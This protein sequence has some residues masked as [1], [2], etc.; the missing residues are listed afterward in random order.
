MD[1]PVLRNVALLLGD[2]WNICLPPLSNSEDTLKAKLGLLAACGGD[3]APT[4]V[5]ALV[6]GT[7]TVLKG[8][9][10][11]LPQPAAAYGNAGQVPSDR[12]TFKEKL[13]NHIFILN[14]LAPFSVGS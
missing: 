7:R 1:A 3:L 8:T 5:Q 10:A 9:A 12:L 13:E 11:C 14:L 4:S 6:K 2:G